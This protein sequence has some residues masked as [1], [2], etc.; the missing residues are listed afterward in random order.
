MIISVPLQSGEI[1]L[2]PQIDYWSIKARKFE[3]GLEDYW[4]QRNAVE[5]AEMSA[6]DEP[7]EVAA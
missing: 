5:E 2:V 1:V 3:K 6:V 7:V 4:M